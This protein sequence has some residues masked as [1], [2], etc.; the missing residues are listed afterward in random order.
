[1]SE[2]MTFCDCVGT[3]PGRAMIKIGLSK[4]GRDR[5]FMCRFC[6]KVR[7]DAY[8]LS[9]TLVK[10]TYHERGSKGLP[11]DIASEVESILKYVLWE[12]L[13]PTSTYGWRE[14]R[15]PS[16]PVHYTSDSGQTTLCG[17]QR[18]DLPTTSNPTEGSPVYIEWR[19]K[20]MGSYQPAYIC[21]ECEERKA[22]ADMR[23]PPLVEELKRRGVQI[24]D[25]LAA[26]IKQDR[27][28]K[29]LSAHLVA[30]HE[31]TKAKRDQERL[32]KLE[33][34]LPQIRDILT[35]SQESASATVT[36]LEALAQLLE[37]LEPEPP[38]F[39]GLRLPKLSED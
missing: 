31:W 33:T 4:R 34:A 16:R 17:L 36:N 38:P 32:E 12:Y 7:W 22:L 37:S 35:Q 15:I 23:I 14:A 30:N 1:M 25:D 19:I 9:G 26:R 28:A 5:F 29:Q 39:F 11:E 3:Q 13:V 2:E 24:S 8:S 20:E 18:K 10:T 27:W 6:G 21:Q